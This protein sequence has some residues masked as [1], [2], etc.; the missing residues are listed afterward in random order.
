MGQQVLISLAGAPLGSRVFLESQPTSGPIERVRALAL[1]LRTGQSVPD[2]RAILPPVRPGAPEVYVPV[3]IVDGKEIRGE[4]FR[5]PEPSRSVVA[6]P[7]AVAREVTAAVVSASSAAPIGAGKEAGL[8][9]PAMELLAHVEA[10]LPS[11]TVF[12]A[13]PEGVR[14]VFDIADGH[15]HGPRIN[16]RYKA[17]GGDWL[18]VRRDGVGIPNVRA[19]LETIDGALLYY[20]LTGNIDLGPGGYERILANEMPDVAPFSAFAR[21]STSSE[22]WKWLNRL[23]L[24]AVG[25]VNLKIRRA[26]YDVYSVECDSAALHR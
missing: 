4:S 18:V 22:S 5:R 3:A 12:G 10:D 14:I 7:I 1:P 6:Q 25:V 21:V 2:F 20:E 17:E 9:F 23:T 11:A 26:I 15:W 16:A 19:T 24:V 13:T 8:P